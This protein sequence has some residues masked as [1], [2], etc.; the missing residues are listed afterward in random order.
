M[1]FSSEYWYSFHY[2]D[3]R[4]YLIFC[5]HGVAT[6]YFDSVSTNAFVI[7]LYIITLQLSFASTGNECRSEY[8][9]APIAKKLKL[10]KLKD[11][12]KGIARNE[13]SRTF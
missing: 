12:F 3:S 2:S 7:A 10:G 11:T 9:V 5:C 6:N 1:G 8:E 13:L 4:G